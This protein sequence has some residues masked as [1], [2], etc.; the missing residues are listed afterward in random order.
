[1]KR[2]HELT[3]EQQANAIRLVTDRILELVTAG[4]IRF[5]DKLNGNNL[6]EVIDEAIK[7]ANSDGVP[8]FAHEYVMAAHYKPSDNSEENSAS[9]S[10]MIK[11]M[12]V[13]TAEDAFYP[14]PGDF[15]E[16]GVLD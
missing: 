6:Q 15:I 10:E 14:E 3:V 13:V 4:A 2:F 1:M 16:W 7:E 11:G 8:W 9:V 5:N 12:A